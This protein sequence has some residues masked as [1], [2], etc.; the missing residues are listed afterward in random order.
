MCTIAVSI[1]ALCHGYGI[2]L[3]HGRPLI[4]RP[5]LSFFCSPFFKANE[6]WIRV[7]VP[8]FPFN[9]AIVQS[10]CSV[11]VLVLLVVVVDCGGYKFAPNWLGPHKSNWAEVL[12]MGTGGFP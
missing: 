9:V 8:L 5:P 4:P 1:P 2:N 7:D 11:L 12:S 10:L 6:T 3:K